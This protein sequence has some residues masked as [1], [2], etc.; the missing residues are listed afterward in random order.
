M[1]RLN[2]ETSMK[3]LLCIPLILLLVLPLVTA[4]PTADDRALIAEIK[5]IYKE[6]NKRLERLVKGLE[7]L[8]KKAEAASATALY[9]MHRHRAP[10]SCSVP[11]ACGISLSAATDS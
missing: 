5:E 9:S 4:A 2:S 3:K 8:R 7:E 11:S 6:R 10:S 1:I